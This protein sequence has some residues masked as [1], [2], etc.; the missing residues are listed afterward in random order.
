MP[1]VIMPS[2][3]LL[4]VVAPSALPFAIIPVAEN[5]KKRWRFRATKRME[6][7]MER[8]WEKTQKIV[9][10]LIEFFFSSTQDL[11]PVL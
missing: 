1:S 10:D 7:P 3:I 6:V 9:I 2:V 8:S 11:G 4:S 5:K